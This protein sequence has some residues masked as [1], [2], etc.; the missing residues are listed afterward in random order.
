VE[1]EKNLTDAWKLLVPQL[2]L[3][4]STGDPDGFVRCS[5]FS[6]V[7]PL[8]KSA[9]F[10]VLM[11]KTSHTLANL[12]RDYLRPYFTMSWMKSDPNTAQQIL[13][14]T[15][16]TPKDYADFLVEDYTFHRSYPK[17]AI[18]VADCKVLG[19]HEPPPYVSNVTHEIVVCDML[20]Y[21]AFEGIL[22]TPLLHL[23]RT[24]FAIPHLYKVEGY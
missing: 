14:N 22:G 11:R 3:M 10:C 9:T 13:L 5:P 21:H 8:N 6:W 18:A 23:G 4:I 16:R 17:E 20:D 24:F 1:T 19:V 2:V 15:Q 12:R 7:V